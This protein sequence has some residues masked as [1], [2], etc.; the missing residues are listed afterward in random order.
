MTLIAE[1]Q[2]LLESDL[3]G[4]INLFV[5]AGF[6]TLA[7]NSRGQT[8]PIGEQLKADIVRDF[9]AREL[10]ALD[11]SSLYTVIASDRRKE[12]RDYLV[13]QYSV[14]NY[15]SRYDALHKLDVSHLYTTN[16]DDLPHHI[17]SAERSN[18]CV[19]HDV[20]DFGAPRNP[21]H[22][23]QYIPLHGSIRHED[24][25]FLFT[26]GQISAAFA[27]DR[28]TWY[29]F[30]RELQVRPTVFIGYAMRDAGVLQALHD[31]TGQ[32]ANRWIILRTGDEATQNL[33]KSLGF[34][35]AVG[36]VSDF[37]DFV[38]K[39][40]KPTNAAPSRSRLLGQVPRIGEFA[41]RPVKN[42]FL[43]AEPEWSDAYSPQ[44]VKQKINL[45]V[46]NSILSGRHVAVVGVP[47]SAKTTIL[48]QVAA[49][50]SLN[51]DV[52]YFDRI[53][54]PTLDMILS[55]H[56]GS[57]SRPLIFVDNL[58][59]SRD[60]I[61]RLAREIGAQIVS[62]EDSLFFDSV[63]LRALSP[64]LDVHSSSEVD[65]ADLQ[66]IIDSIPM[67]V[68]RWNP[69]RISE[70]EGDS[71]EFGLFEAF[72]RHVFD[73]SLTSRFRERLIEFEKKDREAFDVYLMAAYCAKCR[74]YV[75]FDMIYMFID[76]RKKDYIDVY[77]I[78]GRIESFLKEIDLEDDPH[79]DY[80]S[81]RSSALA[82]IALKEVSGKS[83]G[84]MYDRF[85][86]AVPARVIVDYPV[87]R[88]YGY[89][90]DFA[91]R[92][93]PRLEDGLRFYERLVKSSDN[94][95]DYQHGAI[96]L[97]KMKDFSR[98]FSWI[99]TA[100]SKSRGRVFSIRNTH[101]RILFEAN[102]DIAKADPS[103]VTALEGLQESMS[104]LQDCIE[105]DQRRTYHLLRFSDQA[106]QYGQVI[107]DQQ[108]LDW[109][110]LAEKK[111]VAMVDKA[112][113]ARSRESYNLR[114]YR[115]LL[116]EVRSLVISKDR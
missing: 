85:H 1:Q 100:M 32:N 5:G 98:A 15:D 42:F 92:A 26:G 44:V 16:I 99:D 111:L 95:Y 114:K 108:G 87:F 46:K 19:L 11:L 109:L 2:A 60:A 39:L 9:N 12:I 68:R 29:V 57:S 49:D 71:E 82:R 81:V 80:F 102:I 94:A 55:E 77:N 20:Y 112:V 37:L 72:R 76:G 64:R 35:V 67:E 113:V 75:S 115:S 22:V 89:D 4:K 105:K 86:S 27:S 106:I 38:S 6:S 103:D 107:E 17:Y 97:S 13:N 70:M 101:A 110:K 58:I 88:R 34:N 41:Q 43:G 51:R 23:V 83:F 28:E 79:Q 25:E 36:E 66:K 54:E 53:S 3:S 78:A 47:L 18:S 14:E 96:Y 59:D 8:L 45:K 62:A 30:Q 69:D 10:E 90:N 24:S 84:R 52:Y 31:S 73:E 65:R 63:N 61:D 33:Y 93:Y 91:R 74:I 21:E 50:I 40:E 56:R 48:R 104:V 7:R 116:G